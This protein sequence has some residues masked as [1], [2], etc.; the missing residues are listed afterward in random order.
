MCGQCQL[1][2]MWVVQNCSRLANFLELCRSDFINFS[3]LVLKSCLSIVFVTLGEKIY[4]ER[5]KDCYV[6]NDNKSKLNKTFFL[7]LSLLLR[8]VLGPDK[9]VR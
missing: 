8:R 6:F 5:Q 1:S 7:Q 3:C 4:T 2:L 9:L